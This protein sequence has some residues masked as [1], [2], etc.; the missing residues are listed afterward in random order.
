MTGQDK[1][2]HG[3][4]ELSRR[5]FIKVAGLAG[6]ATSL[7]V[8]G[9][10]GAKESS[11]SKGSAKRLPLKVTGYNFDRLAALAQ[12]KVEIEGCD[13]QFTLG[14]IGDM[15]TDVLDGAQTFDVSE[16]GLHPFMLA[17]ANDHFRDY[18]L[19]PVFPII[20]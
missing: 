6:A 10:V 17:Y 5:D 7:M 8:S 13:T 11:M 4:E 9:G 16:I 14:K 19:L 15:N 18:T 12:G 2:D 1:E 3:K 20:K